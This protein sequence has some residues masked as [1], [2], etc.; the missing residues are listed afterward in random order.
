M[1]SLDWYCMN[2]LFLWNQGDTSQEPRTLSWA[3]CASDFNQDPMLAFQEYS[4]DGLFMI[5]T[6]FYKRMWTLDR[7]WEV[8]WQRA[9]SISTKQPSLADALM[10]C[11]D[12][13]LGPSQ[14]P[15]MWITGHSRMSCP[16]RTAYGRIKQPLSRSTPPYRKAAIVTGQCKIPKGW[17]PRLNSEQSWG[18]VPP[19]GSSVRSAKV[20]LQ[21]PHSSAAPSAHLFILY[22]VLIKKALPSQ[23]CAESHFGV[24]CQ[25]SHLSKSSPVWPEVYFSIVS[26]HP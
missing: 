2:E 19:P 26:S 12:P 1:K 18:A 8:T 4:V 6:V 16:P 25:R 21:L 13:P 20:L 7:W 3:N 23:D 11:S 9:H 22:H 24:I 15:G 10:C 17:F 5:L 14:L